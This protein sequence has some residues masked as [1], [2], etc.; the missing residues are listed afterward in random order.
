MNWRQLFIK[1]DLEMLLAEMAGEHRLRRVLGPIGLTSLGVGCIIG[2]GIFVVTGRAAALD[3]GP[4]VIASFAVAAIGCTLAALCYAEFAAMAPVA[5]SAYTYAYTTLGEIFAWIIGWDLILE[6]AM[7]CATVASAWSGYLNEFL[8]A[9]S[10]NKISI[11][12]QVLSDPFTPVEGL[13]GRPWFNLPS[14]LIMALVTA[15]LVVG[16]RESVRTNAILVAIKLF[17][18]V[19]VIAVGWAYVQPS[20]WTDVPYSERLLPEE[21]EIPKIVEKHLADPLA[22]EVSEL[23]RQ[24]SAAYRIQLATQEARRLQSEGRLSTEEADSMIARAEQKAANDFD[25]PQSEADRTAVSHLLSTMDS[26]IAATAAAKAPPSQETIEDLVRKYL[27]EKKQAIPAKPIDRDVLSKQLNAEHRMQWATREADRLQAA[28]RLSAEK[29]GEMVASITEKV[30]PDLPQNEEARSVVKRLLPQVHRLG[31]TKAAD[32]WG[33]LGMLG[34]NRWLLPIDDATRSPFMPYGLSGIMLGAAI[35]FFAFIGFDSI[36][37][38]AEE[39][40]NPQRDAP[41]GILTSLFVCT[42]LYIAVASVVTGMVRYPNIDIKAPIAVAFRETAGAANSTSLRWTTGLISAG[43]L[44]GM[45]SVLLVLFLSQARIF[46]AMSRDG[47]LPSIFGT[48]HPRFRTPHI[49][50][51]VTGAV[52]CLTAALTPIKKLEEMVNV[53]TLMAFV[54]VCAAVMILRRQR[55]DAKRPFRCPAIWLIAPLG[56]AVNLL[57]MLFLPLDTWARLLIWLLIGFVIY[58]CYSRRHSHLMKHLLHEIQT[59]RDESIDAEN[60]P[61]AEG[62]A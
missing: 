40:R 4:A 57:L 48:V 41:I 1:K 19:V 18:V 7:G 23:T 36:S 29:A 60:G 33:M 14:V 20:H 2:A 45:T 56:I 53:G 38:H 39:A 49:A 46:M 35:V 52:I 61:I 13:S 9:I 16:I 28:G 10:N 54:M 55:P 44:A 6:Y 37:T 22:T 30:K 58:F 34:L 43:G 21:Q 3:A 25:L 11:P 12:G 62:N 15:V 50:T 8:L 17:V 59:P 32:S 31:K 42:I 5:G 27:A 24:V 47:L 26:T 51:M